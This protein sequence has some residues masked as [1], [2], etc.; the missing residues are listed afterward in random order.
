MLERLKTDTRYTVGNSHTRQATAI[1]ERPITDTRY[2]VGDYH[3]RQA[4]AIIERTVKDIATHY[5]YFLQRCGNIVRS[6]ISCTACT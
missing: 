4:T 5:R 6:I 1:I 2:A 3:A